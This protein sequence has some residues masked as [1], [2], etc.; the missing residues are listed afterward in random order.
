MTTAIPRRWNPGPALV[1]RRNCRA[2]NARLRNRKRLLLNR[3]HVS[4]QETVVKRVIN[5]GSTF[6]VTQ[7]EPIAIDDL[8]VGDK[9]FEVPFEAL[10]RVL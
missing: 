2:D 9:T 10:E 3:L 8:R 5:L 6:E 7:S 1:P 4:L